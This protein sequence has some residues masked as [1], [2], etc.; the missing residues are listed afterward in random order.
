MTVIEAIRSRRSTKAFTT[1]PVGRD[2]VETLLDLAVLA[3]NHRMTAPWRFLVL[4]PAAR[5]AYGNVLGGRKAKKVADAEVARVLVEKTVAEA[6]AAPLMIAVTQTL[7]D[8]PEILEE[9]YAA[10]WMAIQNILL[11]AVELGLGTHLRTGAVFSDPAV[12]SAW[13]VKDGERVV[14]VILVGTPDGESPP[15]TRVSAAERTEW[16]A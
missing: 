13:S 7:S 14:G 3:P 5:R 11:G 1:A 9:D 15:K 10:T 2:H 16:L 6:V 8:N 4:G 12:R